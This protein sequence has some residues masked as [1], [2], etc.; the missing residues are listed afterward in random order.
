MP[1]YDGS[2]WIFPIVMPIVMLIVVFVA[3]SMFR[4]AI[5]GPWQP[6]SRERDEPSRDD[7]FDILRR[8]FAR[9]EVTEEE[10]ER[11]REVLRR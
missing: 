11:L 1:W 10:Y 5:V 6:W 3:L 7:S 4:G 8:R 2:W 9:G